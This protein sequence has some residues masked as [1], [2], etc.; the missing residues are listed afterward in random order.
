MGGIKAVIFD[1]SGTV[2]DFGSRAP[3]EAF[4]E[5]FADRG[6]MIRDDEA[7]GPMGLGK[8]H[9]I[10]VLARLPRIAAAW[11][12]VHGQDIMAGDI[13]RLHGILEKRIKDTALRRS[14]LIP[15][16]ADVVGDLRRRG[17]RIGST[18]GYPR[19]VLTPLARLAETQGFA[20]EVTV[21]SDDLAA[22][23]PTP[24]MM[25]RCFIDLAVWPA[26]A[27][28]KVDDTAPG[29]AEAVAA[30]SWAVGVTLSGNGVGLD[31]NDLARLDASEIGRLR[32]R[33]AAPLHEAGAHHVI[34][35]VVDL[36]RAID[37]IAG[38]L[39]AG[40]MPHDDRENGR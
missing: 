34:D 3:V 16:T 24:L 27:V 23:R 28:V 33:A 17:V 29:I 2:V 1:W 15:G 39:A 18:T 40:H 7:R 9:H 31:E 4:I 26:S 32:T 5:I 10:E 6:V 30:G 13:D 22:G 36:P 8:R 21:C 19:S 12:H 37:D 25:Y 35:T 38:S 11:R 20:P 14:A